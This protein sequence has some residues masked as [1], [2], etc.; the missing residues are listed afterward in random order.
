MN[1]PAPQDS[2]AREETIFFAAVQL[3]DLAKR[4]LY[5]EMACEN[6]ANLKARIERL[7]AADSAN[8][9]LAGR[10]VR[11]ARMGAASVT[12]PSPIVGAEPRTIPKGGSEE[13]PERIGRYKLLQKIG[14]VP[15]IQTI[16]QLL[17][18]KPHR[19]GV[20]TLEHIK[21]NVGMRFLQQH[22]APDGPRVNKSLVFGCHLVV[23]HS[24]KFSPYT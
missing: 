24:I 18:V 12:A 14:E 13:I 9:V 20:E 7:L 6:D 15:S 11:S 8:Q 16:S 1:E 4:A 5:L 21:S 10:A 22:N 19:V 2:I 23:P 3:K 17:W